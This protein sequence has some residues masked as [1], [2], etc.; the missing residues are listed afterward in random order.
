[1]RGVIGDLYMVMVLR[2]EIYGGILVDWYINLILFWIFFWLVFMW[3]RKVRMKGM[4]SDSM[5]SC[6]M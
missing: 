2:M 3:F 6:G 5:N 1:M 4:N